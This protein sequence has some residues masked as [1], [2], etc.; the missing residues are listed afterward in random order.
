MSVLKPKS[1]VKQESTLAFTLIELLVVIAIIAILAAMLLPV[2]AKAKSRAQTAN[3]LNT[4]RQW[5]IAMGIYAS[6]GADY[7]PRDGTDDSGLYTYDNNQTTGPGTPNDPY[8]W[9]NTLPGLVGDKPLSYYYGLPGSY[10][11]KLPFPDNGQGK[12]FLCPAAR[13]ADADLSQW[14]K[15]PTAGA[16]SIDMNIDLKATTPLGSAYGKLTY[17]NM[18]KYSKVPRS[19]STVLLSEA[20]FSPTL[21]NNIL[22]NPSDNSRNG[23]YPCNRSYVFP[24]RHDG[25]GGNIVF[26]DGHASFFKRSY[27]TNGAPNGSGV[28][29]AEKDNG[30]V[31]WDIYRN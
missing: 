4:M 31:I 23:L 26:L 30:D 10:I 15:P 9:F 29:R 27:I 8:A 22:P 3:C 18:P 14:F 6:D 20:L 13:Y 16:L 12:I 7:I 24:L 11:V 5:G 19:A 28:N 1:G 17:P 2:L 21:E 25:A